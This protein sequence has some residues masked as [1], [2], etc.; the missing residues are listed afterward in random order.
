MHQKNMDKQW[1]IIDEIP[2]AIGTKKARFF[3]CYVYFPLVNYH[4]TPLNLSAD[5]YLYSIYFM[6]SFPW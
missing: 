2:P 6:D 4:A 3:L 5:Y 1:K